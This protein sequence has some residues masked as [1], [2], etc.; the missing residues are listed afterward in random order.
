MSGIER[1]WA[2]HT[3]S[4]IIN[5]QT[6][7][8]R[9]FTKNHQQTSNTW[10]K[11][12]QICPCFSNIMYMHNIHHNWEA[13]HSGQRLVSCM[14]IRKIMMILLKTSFTLTRRLHPRFVSR[15]LITYQILHKSSADCPES[16]YMRCE[17]WW[18]WLTHGVEWL[19]R[20]GY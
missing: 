13:S 14:D 15:Y 19:S 7:K 2:T 12:T 8:F 16:R 18:Q 9:H 4:V 6:S 5:M 11:A 17:R 20:N 1:Q 3:Y 10:P